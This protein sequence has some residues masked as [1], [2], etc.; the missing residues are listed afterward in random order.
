MRKENPSKASRIRYP[1]SFAID[2]ALALT[3]G[4]KMMLPRRSE[5]KNSSLAAVGANSRGRNAAFPSL[6]PAPA[7]PCRSRTGCL[8]TRRGRHR[9]Y[10]SAPEFHVRRRR[11][12][13]GYSHGATSS[14]I[15]MIA[16]A[17]LGMMRPSLF[18]FYLKNLQ[19]PEEDKSARFGTF[20]R[21]AKPPVGFA[22]ES[23]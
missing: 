8:R 18:R 16:A 13:C 22:A 9:G 23:H 20:Y 19:L 15:I 21:N 6:H 11:G 2:R 14:A 1:V 12:S 5:G 3:A 4:A 10:S 17:P 7:D